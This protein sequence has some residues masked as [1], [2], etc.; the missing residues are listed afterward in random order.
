MQSTGQAGRHLSHPLHSSGT[1][2]TSAPWLKI[3]PNVGGQ[4]RRQASQLMHSSISMRRGT[5][6]HFS[7]RV[8][9]AIRSSRVT[10]VIAAVYETVGPAADRPVHADAVRW[11]LTVGSRSGGSRY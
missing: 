7:L 1:M 10:A 11:N 8:L 9:V 4:W 5:F 3:A 6:C 2:I